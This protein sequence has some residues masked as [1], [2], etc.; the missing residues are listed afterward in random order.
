MAI[1]I[2]FT[3]IVYAMLILIVVI[4][5][6]SL[7]YLIY[8]ILV[9]KER[10]IIYKE[11]GRDALVLVIK[12]AR[13]INTQSG[14]ALKLW[15]IKDPV[16]FH[17]GCFIPIEN[18]KNSSAIS[19]YQDDAG[20]L[21]P[22]S[23]VTS[24]HAKIG[25]EDAE[26]KIPAII[27]E[28]VDTKSWRHYELRRTEKII[29]RKGAMQTLMPMTI[30]FLVIVGILFV[31][32]MFFKYYSQMATQFAQSFAPISEAIASGKIPLNTGV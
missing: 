10:A 24:I 16:P 29:E 32:I 7:L 20:D 26:L 18:K 12:R 6:G 19:L 5:G 21:H 17:E 30:Y 4:L 25:G 31:M 11:R 1:A 27:P 3:Q 28:D 22:M 8:F 15:F 14:T 13:R 23:F 9:W 2:G